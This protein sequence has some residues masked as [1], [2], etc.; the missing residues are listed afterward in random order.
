MVNQCSLRKQP[1]WLQRCR[2]YSAMGLAIALLC[3]GVFHAEGLAQDNASPSA[4]AAPEETTETAP[5]NSLMPS[6]QDWLPPELETLFTDNSPDVE[7]APVYLDGRALFELTGPAEGGIWTAA[8]RANIVES[9]LASLAQEIVHQGSLEGLLVRYEIDVNSNQPVI[10]VNGKVLMTVTFLDARLNGFE[11]LS[12]WATQV[13]EDIEYALARYY[14]ER[15][16]DFLWGQLR[17]TAVTVLLTL[18]GSFALAHYYQQLENRRQQLKQGQA[19]P[20]TIADPHDASEQAVVNHVRNT[21]LTRQRV[22]SLKVLEQT[23]QIGQVALWGSSLFLIAGFFPY[24]RWLQPL[25]IGALRLP[26]RFLLIALVAYGL[27]RLADIWI[28]RVFLAVQSRAALTMEKTQRLA[29]RLSTLSE[30]VQGC[31]T[32][33]IAL[34]ALMIMLSQLGIQV[35]PILA[36][37]GIVGVALSFASQSLIK[38]IINGFL[39]LIEDQYGVGDVISVRGISGFVETM[40]LRMTQLRDT[41]GRLTTVPNGQIDIVQNLSKEWSR[42]DLGIPVGLEADINQASRLME[43]IAHEMSQDGIWGPLILEP[44]LLLGIDSLDDLGATIRIWIKT[45]PLKQWDVAREYRRRLKI[46]FEA[47]RISIGVP[48]QILHINGPLTAPLMNAPQHS[49]AEKTMPSECA[50]TSETSEALAEDS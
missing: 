50:D 27:A 19:E 32:V 35:T 17:W 13:A 16:P 20:Q 36:G 40:N 9:E 42:V 6:W 21:V 7:L 46:A 38:D 31:V 39:I 24:I 23:V 33:A 45:Q 47:A 41:E 34:I 18:L 29:L 4:P 48:Q 5:E 43:Q 44:P 3:T 8:R 1:R 49:V 30:V 25:T 26:L 10:Y 11:N 12:L 2:C 37:A 15:Q 22:K 28:D 14:R